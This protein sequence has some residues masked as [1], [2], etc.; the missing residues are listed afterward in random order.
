M[1][2]EEIQRFCIQGT[3]AYL[4]HLEANGGGEEVVEVRLVERM[5][6]GEESAAIFKLVLTARVYG[7]EGI[8]IRVLPPLHNFGPPDFGILEYDADARCLLV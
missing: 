4:G 1:T 7:T 2:P 3:D 5:S 6:A 8:G